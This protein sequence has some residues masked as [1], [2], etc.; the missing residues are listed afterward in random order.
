MVVTECKKSHMSLTVT[1]A[2]FGFLRIASKLDWSFDFI[3]CVNMDK[4]ESTFSPNLQSYAWMVKATQ[5]KRAPHDL[6]CV[7][8]H[9]YRGLSQRE[10]GC[11]M[12]VNAIR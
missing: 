12:K 6:Y 9:N 5:Q 8:E 7:E 1:T 3:M 10:P 11:D 2:S 4:R